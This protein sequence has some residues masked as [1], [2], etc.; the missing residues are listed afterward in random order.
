MDKMNIL[1]E[2][3]TENN[4]ITRGNY[5]YGFKKANIRYWVE[6]TK[7][8][9]VAWTEQHEVVVEAENKESAH[10]ISFSQKRGTTFKNSIVNEIKR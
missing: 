1:K 7:A 5:P 8:Y 4:P 9:K 6:T 10:I 3:P 2:Q